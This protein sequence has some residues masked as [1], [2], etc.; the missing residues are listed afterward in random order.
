MST[1]NASDEM[2]YGVIKS[3]HIGVKL[4]YDHGGTADH[5]VIKGLP[6]ST[7]NDSG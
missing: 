6:I 1:L 4:L 2:R 3:V 7:V 5:D